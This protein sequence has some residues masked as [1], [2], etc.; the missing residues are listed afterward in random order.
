MCTSTFTT[1]V[2]ELTDYKINLYH[3]SSPSDVFVG[4]NQPLFTMQSAT[5]VLEL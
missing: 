4:F 3:T 2:S 5:S 1:W